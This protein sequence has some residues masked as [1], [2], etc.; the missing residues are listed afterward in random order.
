MAHQNKRYTWG[1][2]LFLIL[3]LVAGITLTT[4]LWNVV[5]AAPLTE[6]TYQFDCD[7]IALNIVRNGNSP[8]TATIT[9][10]KGLWVEIPPEKPGDTIF[11]YNIVNSK[12]AKF[13]LTLIGGVEV[14]VLQ[15][16]RDIDFYKAHHSQMNLRCKKRV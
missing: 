6:K 9:T 11:F 7:G 2:K 4:A 15:T 14:P 3:L 1:A 8:L 16:Y 13:T 10:E 12:V 5:S